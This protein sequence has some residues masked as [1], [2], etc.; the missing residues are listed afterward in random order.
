[1]WISATA[2]STGTRAAVSAARTSMARTASASTAAAMTTAACGSMKPP[3]T[4]SATATSSGWR[5]DEIA[6]S[7][8]RRAGDLAHL[9]ALEV[10]ER[11]DELVARVH[12]EGTVA[13]DGLAERR[14]REEQEA[15]GTVRPQKP[16]RGP[17]TEHGH[18]PFPDLGT[19]RSEARGSLEDVHECLE[20]G[21]DFDADVGPRLQRPV[22][23][24]DRRA[25]LD[26]GAGSQRLAR[27]HAHRCL[28]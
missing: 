16:H 15:T 25:R 20:A 8:L 13:G 18:L 6:S 10:V 27:D 26:D 9:A 4:S 3:C 2:A 17:R 1:M 23:Q 5:N 12:H 22:L 7:H 11:L 14:T 19:C 21:R 28:A 24:D